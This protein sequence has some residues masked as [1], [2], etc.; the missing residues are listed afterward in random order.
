MAEATRED[1][2]RFVSDVRLILEGPDGSQQDTEPRLQTETLERLM[3]E[4]REVD[5]LVKQARKELRRT[6][7]VSPS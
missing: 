2:V 4:L 6:P 3:D 5:E 1:L 7:G